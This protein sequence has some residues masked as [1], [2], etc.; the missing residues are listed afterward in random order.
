MYVW[1]L[2]CVL[3]SPSLSAICT[4]QFVPERDRGGGIWDGTQSVALRLTRGQRDENQGMAGAGESHSQMRKQHA[5]R[6]HVACWEVC[7]WE[8]ELNIS[9]VGVCGRQQRTTWSYMRTLGVPPRA[10][11]LTCTS[12]PCSPPPPRPVLLSLYSTPAWTPAC[13]NTLL[14]SPENQRI[15]WTLEVG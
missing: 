4:S 1:E 2:L 11:G 10:I 7:V 5:A 12:P 3:N 13:F 14:C 9:A 8:R 15:G 6:W